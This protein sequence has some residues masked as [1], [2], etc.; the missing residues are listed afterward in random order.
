MKQKIIY[1]ILIVLIP[2]SG[3]VGYVLG[4][5]GVGTPYV[6]KFVHVEGHT[7]GYVKRFTPNKLLLL[8]SHGQIYVLNLTKRFPKLKMRIVQ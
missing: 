1:I 7:S 5:K 2:I 6:G 8:E 3:G 4:L